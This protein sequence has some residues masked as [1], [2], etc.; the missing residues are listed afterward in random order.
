MYSYQLIAK[1]I[2]KK[3]KWVFF[4][5][6]IDRVFSHLARQLYDTLTPNVLGSFQCAKLTSVLLEVRGAMDVVNVGLVTIVAKE[7]TILK[8][9]RK[10]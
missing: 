4:G 2:R 1:L 3:H 9:R 8:R 7:E 5:D 10:R 6:H